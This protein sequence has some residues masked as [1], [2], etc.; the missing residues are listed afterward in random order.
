MG[1]SL[2]SGM[3]FFL[4]ASWDEATARCLP[5][6]AHYEPIKYVYIRNKLEYDSHDTLSSTLSVS[7]V[8]G[9]MSHKDGA[10]L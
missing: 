4:Y 3:V 2:A 10:T 8:L 7:S 6:E 9:P 5:C 1:V